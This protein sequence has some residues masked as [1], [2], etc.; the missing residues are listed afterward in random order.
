MP[1]SSQR[2]EGGG[3][4]VCANTWC[5]RPSGVPAGPE[6]RLLGWGKGVPHQPS[7]LELARSLSCMQLVRWTLERAGPA[8]I[9]WGQWSA[10]RPDLFPPGTPA[11]RH[12]SQH[13]SLFCRPSLWQ[14]LP[15]MPITPRCCVSG[16]WSN[17][18][19]QPLS[20]LS[21]QGVLAGVCKELLKLHTK[22]PQSV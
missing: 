17:P 20:K 13:L 4:H 1:L 11:S 22:A 16:L 8:F 12:P 5:C 7:W 6:D 9:K 14:T 10:T 18:A 19:A 15:R 3:S 21:W 2:Q